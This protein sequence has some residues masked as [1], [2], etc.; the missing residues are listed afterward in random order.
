MNK[1]TCLAF[2]T[3]SLLYFVEI[4]YNLLFFNK[5]YFYNFEHHTL[6]VCMLVDTLHRQ[7]LKQG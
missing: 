2:V 4:T 6:N 3:S 5:N 1:G 7:R